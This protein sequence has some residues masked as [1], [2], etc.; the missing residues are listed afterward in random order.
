MRPLSELK[1]GDRV[2]R[3]LAETV[4]MDL[5][6]V[7]IDE[8]LIHCARTKDE[9]DPDWIWTFDARYAF[10][11]DEDLGWGMGP[12][13]ITGSR[14]VGVLEEGDEGIAEPDELGE[15]MAAWKDSQQ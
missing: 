8:R 5:W 6:V 3:L 10:E 13:P 7:K 2:R 4:P 1:V 9:T 11:V 15:R 12:T 14:L